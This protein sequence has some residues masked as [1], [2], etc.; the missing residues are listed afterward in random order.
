MTKF[1]SLLLFCLLLTFFTWDGKKGFIQQACGQTPN[2]VLPYAH[3]QSI[4]ALA[5]S[6][7]GNFMI[8]GDAGGEIKIWDLRNGIQA[9]TIA[10]HAESIDHL[11]FSGDRVFV[12]GGKDG[13]VKGW[14][15][16][17][18]RLLK[19]GGGMG[20]PI[21]VVGHDTAKSRL[22][23]RQDEML[24][25]WDS[26]TLRPTGGATSLKGVNAL[27][28]SSHEEKIFCSPDLRYLAVGVESRLT[29]YDTHKQSVV[30]TADKIGS[31]GIAGVAFSD[32][33]KYL[34]LNFY[35]STEVNLIDL[36]SGGML[37][38]I[39]PPESEFKPDYWLGHYLPALTFLHDDSNILITAG[40]DTRIRTWD[41]R[42]GREMSNYL[43]PAYSKPKDRPI[44]A[45]VA[46][47]AVAPNDRYFV[48]AADTDLRVWSVR[49]LMQRADLRI[50][51]P[52]TFRMAVIHPDCKRVSTAYADGSIHTFDAQTGALSADAIP[53]NGE[54]VAALKLLDERRLAVKRTNGNWAI[55]DWKNAEKVREIRSQKIGEI[56][57]LSA[58]TIIT[59]VDSQLQVVQL[60][61]DEVLFTI[62]T[63][64]GGAQ[65]VALSPDGRYL[66]FSGSTRL[67]EDDQN[68]PLRTGLRIWS[69][70]ERKLLNELVLDGSSP[71][72]GL[73]F[74]ADG[75]RLLLTEGHSFATVRFIDVQSVSF[76]GHFTL[77]GQSPLEF[78]SV[79]KKGRVEFMQLLERRPPPGTNDGYPLLRVSEETLSRQSSYRKVPPPENIAALHPPEVQLVVGFE[80]GGVMVYQFEL[81]LLQVSGPS[82]VRPY[83]YAPFH[84]WYEKGEVR[85]FNLHE[86]TVLDARL[87]DGQDAVL[88]IGRDGM[89]RMSGFIADEADIPSLV[90]WRHNVAISTM[91][92]GKGK[93]SVLLGKAD[94]SVWSWNVLARQPLRQ[95]QV[96]AEQITSIGLSDDGSYA[97]YSDA[98][99]NVIAGT[100]AG[101]H[102]KTMDNQGSYVGTHYGYKWLIFSADSR[103]LL[104]YSDWYVKV[105]D[106]AS[107]KKLAE[108]FVGA[109]VS[110]IGFSADGSQVHV[111][112]REHEYNQ[113]QADL[114]VF[115]ALTGEAV[116]SLFDQG[117]EVHSLA[118]DDQGAS[119]VWMIDKNR[120]TAHR[121][122][123]GFPIALRLDR[124]PG[125]LETVALLENGKKVLA[126]T[127]ARAFLVHKRTGRRTELPKQAI[128]RLMEYNMFK[129]GLIISEGD[130]VLQIESGQIFIID[131]ATNRS[132]TRPL[133]SAIELRP[134]NDSLLLLLNEQNELVW[135]DLKRAQPLVTLYLPGKE[136]FIA[137][138]GAGQYYAS[139]G[140]ALKL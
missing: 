26:H 54:G 21:Q 52:G 20:K 46:L 16:T 60:D 15:L 119:L 41:I 69:L 96:H 129:D 105:W 132:V 79:G 103:H 121:V 28:S 62:P 53:G 23:V 124:P 104:G 113:R 9:R 78:T 19:S 95:T 106:P 107:G 100:P 80:E 27:L 64:T 50:A 47:L 35:Q 82:L 66:A 40:N 75:N 73:Q 97:A 84:P 109:D 65:V 70:L 58:N 59:A 14:D 8:S 25:I 34:A 32:D 39:S 140:A 112:I 29:V 138:T 18:G 43:P 135:Y 86:N 63:Y 89:L 10:A 139:K 74:S 22:L 94:G 115:D 117:A 55:Y 49:G 51:P 81:T 67:P 7:D 101:D 38:T 128:D 131:P 87:P 98:K 83:P 116:D 123:P 68:E 6:P 85:L 30:Y 133:P 120:M 137:F 118:V 88:S 45:G 99:G 36:S 127:G 17:T 76:I 136:D 31:S 12:S 4:T 61:S 57:A 56:R 2:L 3:V 110:D 92:V 108:W 102:L 5:Y 11:S 90:Q 71:I 44:L 24:E 77:V 122:A 126:V 37:R 130:S 91:A 33:G 42:T 134:F 48:S 13:L 114:V 72:N 93:P 125:P 1:Q 111:A